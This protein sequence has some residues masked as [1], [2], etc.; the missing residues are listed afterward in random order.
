MVAVREE[1]AP[2]AEGS[3]ASLH[4]LRCEAFRE[5]L[6]RYARPDDDFAEELAEVY[7]GFRHVSLPP[8]PAVVECLTALTSSYALGV[9]SNGNTPPE[10]LG[11]GELFTHRVYAEQVGMGKPERGIFEHAA[12]VAGARPGGR[13]LVGDSPRTDIAG[14]RAAGWRAVWF[15]PDGECWPL[16][17][18]P[19]PSFV[20][21]G[22]LPDLLAQLD[23]GS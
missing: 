5:T 7:Y 12:R 8:Y 9:L 18:D 1:L 16:E 20:D 13:L 6:R 21:F 15:C 10:Q 17:D 11:L 4:E 23:G 22:Q 19:P 14:A 2:L 3:G